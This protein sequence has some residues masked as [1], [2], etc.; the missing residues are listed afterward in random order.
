VGTEQRAGGGGGGGTANGADGRGPRSLTGRGQDDGYDDPFD[1]ILRMMDSVY[2]KVDTLH[3]DMGCLKGLVGEYRGDGTNDNGDEER[4]EQYGGNADR[5]QG[6][7]SRQAARTTQWRDAQDRLVVHSVSEGPGSTRA[8]GEMSARVSARTQSRSLASRLQT[9]APMMGDAPED[10]AVQGEVNGLTSYRG[11]GY[12][13]RVSPRGTNDNGRGGGEV[14]SASSTAATGSSDGD[15]L[16]DV[17][18]QHVGPALGDWVASDTRDYSGVEGMVKVWSPDRDGGGRGSRSG[19]RRQIDGGA[20]R[21]NGRRG[22]PTPPPSN[23]PPP[24][25]PAQPSSLASPRKEPSTGWA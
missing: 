17:G 18:G 3:G 5:D 8:A 12:S 10:G 25:T 24:G 2:V 23:P 14:R 16:G 11:G 9:Q 21:A 1:R 15:S 20:T 6:G 4:D 7:D 19:R 22:R 13:T